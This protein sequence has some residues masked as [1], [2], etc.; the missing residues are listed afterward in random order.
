MDLAGMD[1]L[2]KQK[3]MKMTILHRAGGVWHQEEVGR[4]AVSLQTVICRRP[5]F[6]EHL[7]AFGHYTKEET[8]KALI[9]GAAYTATQIIG[10]YNEKLPFTPSFI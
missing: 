5:Q 9:N 3:K 8:L 10:L 1:I 4:L 2:E 7:V 6:P